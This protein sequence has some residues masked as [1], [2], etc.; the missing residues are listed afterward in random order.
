MIAAP[1][2]H[3]WTTSLGA[4]HKLKSHRLLW[5]STVVLAKCYLVSTI[6][7]TRYKE[8]LSGRTLTNQRLSHLVGVLPILIGSNS[9]ARRDFSNV[10]LLSSVSRSCSRLKLGDIAF[11]YQL[12]V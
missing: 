2:H 5:G 3:G 11:G 12:R 6:V 9:Y 4:D 7:G 10:T 8:C 1:R